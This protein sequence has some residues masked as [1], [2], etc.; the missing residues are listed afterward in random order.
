M[1]PTAQ[2]RPMS[3]VVEQGGEL[4]ALLV[5]QVGEVVPMP[6]RGMTANPPTLDPLFAFT[7]KL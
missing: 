2:P 5:D 3:V 7:G 1:T 6:G 4:Y